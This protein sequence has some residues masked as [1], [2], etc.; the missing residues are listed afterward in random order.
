MHFLG[1]AVTFVVLCAS[2]VLGH[3]IAAPNKH[4]MAPVA[5]AVD[6]RPDGAGGSIDCNDKPP[7][8]GEWINITGKANGAARKRQDDGDWGSANL[9]PADGSHP[10]RDHP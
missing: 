4:F 8:D 10:T 9:G 5:N 1:P 6:L 7:S 3:P 2:S